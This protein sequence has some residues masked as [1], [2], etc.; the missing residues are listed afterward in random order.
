[1]GQLNHPEATFDSPVGAYYPFL[2]Y[3][4]LDRN[5]DGIAQKDEVLLNEGVQY[6]NAVDPAH[7]TA[8]SAVNKIDPNYKS[9]K[10]NEIIVGL[11]REVGGNFAVGVAYT[12]RKVNDIPNFQPRIGLTSA[13]Y[14]VSDTASQAGFATGI[15]YA[16]DPDLVAASGSGRILT[17][18]A[19][20][21]TGYG[22][23]ELTAVKRLSHKWFMRGAFSY[24]NWKEY[25]DGPGAV[26]NPTRTDYFVQAGING[27]SGPQV[28]GGQVAPRSSGSGKGD[29]FF[30]GKWQFVANGLYQV[31]HGFELGASVF[32]RQGYAKPPIYFLDTG[33]D[34][35]PRV[36]ASGN[37][38]DFRYPSLWDA[39]FR[40]ADR[41][42]L[43]GRTQIELSA[44]LFNAF[45][46]NTTL[47]QSRNVQSS[48]YNTINDNLAP[49]ILRIGVRLL[50]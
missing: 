23:L 18:R 26:Q 44:D 43:S 30:N 25:Y 16:P 4:W 41:I 29:I 12:W 37:I 33:A 6:S 39:D 31:G 32:G 49:R 34:G 48:A 19:D 2:A 47:G 27:F 1:A 17:N 10:A 46:S 11:D 45:N 15:A 9:N 5:H 35:T 21:H 50:F 22:G 8:L 3:K 20:Y 24:M 13:N 14:T 36:M 38:D 7:P 42:K 40:L 28:D